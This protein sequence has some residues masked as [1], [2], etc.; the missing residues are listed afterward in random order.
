MR[1][2]LKRSN[3]KTKLISAS[4][5]GPALQQNHTSVSPC[6]RGDTSSS[7]PLIQ[8]FYLDVVVPER[9][10]E[11]LAV[12]FDFAALEVEGLAAER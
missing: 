1:G 8:P 7:G 9:E 3:H 11:V 10:I 2:T 12:D 5:I 4:G 6:L